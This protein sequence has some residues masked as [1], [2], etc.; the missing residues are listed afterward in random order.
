MINHLV[1]SDMRLCEQ[2]YIVALIFTGT[3]TCMNA[4]LSRLKWSL[5]SVLHSALARLTTSSERAHQAITS[6]KTTAEHIDRHKQ[7]KQ[8]CVCNCSIQDMI[9]RLVLENF[10]CFRGRHEIAFASTVNCITGPNGSGA[11]TC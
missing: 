8:C 3:K 2:Q 10:K 4:C 11:C 1:D 7:R 9:E 5:S 6:H